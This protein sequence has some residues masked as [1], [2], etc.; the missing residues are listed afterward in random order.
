MECIVMKKIVSIVV[1]FLVAIILFLIPKISCNSITS[2]KS[3][4]MVPPTK[5][6]FT[7]DGLDTISY[8]D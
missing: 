3:I 5:I 2:S 7:S 8:R 6:Q 4:E 1:I